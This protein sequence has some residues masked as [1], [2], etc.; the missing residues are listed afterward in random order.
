[1]S[2]L[3]LSS[4][5]S[6][7][8][9]TPFDNLVTYKSPDHITDSEYERYVDLFYAVRII[10]L[11]DFTDDYREIETEVNPLLV[12]K[13]LGD[14]NWRSMIVGAFFSAIKMYTELT[15]VLG[16]NLLKSEY[17]YQGRGVALSFASFQT[18]EA[19][20]YLKKYL[21]YYL[22]REDLRYNQDYAAC[23]LKW[24]DENKGSCYFNEYEE[25]YLKWSG[26]LPRTFDSIY[27]EFEEQMI[28][29]EDLKD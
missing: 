28:I 1:M 24:I 29:I 7:Y 3:Y 10:N 20:H 9:N 16:V 23:S 25:K 14:C 12:L 19:I 11:P 5:N 8:I 17:V 4:M 15:D 18:V 21:D 2:L 26:G 22:T 13:L 27:K 6:S